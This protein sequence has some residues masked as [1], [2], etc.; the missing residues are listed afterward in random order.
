M[1][2]NEN[3]IV[4]GLILIIILGLLTYNLFTT[5]NKQDGIYLGITNTIKN[6]FNLFSGIEKELEKDIIVPIENELKHLDKKKEVFNIDQN[7]FNY[8]EASNLCKAF[9]S[10]LATYDQVKDSY[11]NGA[12]WCNY[13][14]S[15]NQ[16]ALY[17]TQKKT[18]DTLQKKQKTK[19]NCG[20][21]GMN[22]GYFKDD[23]LKFGVNCY[24][25]KPEPQKDKIIY[26]DE[27]IHKQH[28][29][30]KQKPSIN[31]DNIDIRPFNNEKWSEY[32][33]KKSAYIINP[34]DYDVDVNDQLTITSNIGENNKIPNLFIS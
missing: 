11:D 13:G 24:G 26:I 10:E 12:E 28:I 18:W 31:I 5:C 34:K 33:F 20:K 1:L 22:G 3:I 23:H 9:D 25:Y 7:V 21:P 29:E 8:E 2:S 19:D 14:W 15:A 4:F 27:N 30:I 32:S 17:P 16:M 6:I